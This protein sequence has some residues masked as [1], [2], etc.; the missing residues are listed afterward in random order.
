MHAQSLQ[1][2]ARAVSW[3]FR[4]P[5][6]GTACVTVAVLTGISLVRGERLMLVL[7]LSIA[8]GVVAFSLRPETLFLGWFLLA[9][10]LQ[11]SAD[12]SP[13]GHNLATGLYLA[14]SLI[15]LVLTFATRGRTRSPTLIDALPAAYFMYVIALFALTRTGIPLSTT[16]SLKAIYKT[17]GIGVIGYYFLVFGPSW[18]ITPAR[19]MRVILHA[20]IVVSLMGIV[21]GVV[22]WNL[23]NDQGWHGE[24]S[25]AVA[26]LANPAVFGA[27]IGMC[28]AIAVAILVWNGPPALRREAWLVIVLGLPSVCLSLTRAPILAVAVAGVMIAASRSETRLWAAGA[29]IVAAVVLI[30][31]WGRIESTGLYQE[32][33]TNSRNVEARVVLQDWSLELAARRPIFGWGYNSFD[34]VKNSTDLGS[35]NLPVAFGLQNTSHNT[36]LTILVEYG[37]VGLVL[38]LIPWIVISWRAVKE[39]IARRETRWLVTGILGAISVYVITASTVDMRFFSF[40][41]AVPWI[42]LGLLRR[43]QRTERREYASQ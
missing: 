12:A 16:E 10:L 36:W 37:G 21:D 13:L 38:L 4:G 14:P 11:N 20:G 27:F 34:R 35:G 2:G 32:R 33:V 22:Q 40:V 39:V 31:S 15:L 8:G 42:L 6:I 23:W 24:T 18:R 26:T 9:P 5:L 29:A 19:L 30:A 1:L 43:H 28:L 17:V 41:P 7:L 25:R 3:R